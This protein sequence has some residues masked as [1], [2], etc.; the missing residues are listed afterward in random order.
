M[1]SSRHRLTLKDRGGL[2]HVLIQGEK[3]SYERTLTAVKEIAALC[4][5]RKLTK[6]LVEHAVGGRLSTLDVYK[7]GAQLPELYEG[8]TVGFV[9]HTAEVPEN[10]GFIQD[11]ARNRGALGRLFATIQEAEDWLRSLPD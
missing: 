9:I 8:I 6:V 3:D 1:A 2:L 4:R 7:I 5:K 11:V 10:P